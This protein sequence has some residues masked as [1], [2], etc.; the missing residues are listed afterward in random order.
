MLIKQKIR[1]KIKEH[2]VLLKVLKI[3]LGKDKDLQRL[4]RF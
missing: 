4:Q 3:N 2:I 1:I